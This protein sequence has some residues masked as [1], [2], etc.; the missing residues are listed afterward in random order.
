[1]ATSI[2]QITPCTGCGQ[3]LITGEK[4][5]PHCGKDLAEAQKEPVA[6]ARKPA[7]ANTIPCP[8]CGE[9]VTRRHRKCPACRSALPW[10]AKKS[11][12][13][14]AAEKVA[15]D[16]EQPALSTSAQ[17]PPVVESSSHAE[18]VYAEP[19]KSPPTACASVP[20]QPI[21][22][23]DPS[24]AKTGP[25]EVEE[26][27]LEAAPTIE[28][29][30]VP[31]PILELGPQLSVPEPPAEQSLAEAVLA[32]SV[33]VGLLVKEQK[34]AEEPVRVGGEAKMVVDEAVSAG[35]MTT[36]EPST[37]ESAVVQTPEVIASAPSIPQG[38]PI[39]AL[40]EVHNRFGFPT[41][42]SVVPWTPQDTRAWLSEHFGTPPVDRTPV[43]AERSPGTPQGASAASVPD[44]QKRTKVIRKRRLKLKV[45]GLQSDHPRLEK[46]I[47]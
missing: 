7:K 24:G 31:E 16:V 3:T 34:L 46:N 21:D 37:S 15:A 22:S 39:C 38:A 10:A 47:A 11:T 42:D 18:P 40:A 28:P 44:D 14:K 9:M 23:D 5:C 2:E 1:M 8:F 29:P 27:K 6:A 4:V 43:P 30:P 26:T 41:C 32:E 12:S 20:T 25:K 19:V 13:S 45:A 33:A 36:K 35:F 17:I